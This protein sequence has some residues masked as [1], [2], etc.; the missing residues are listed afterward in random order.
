MSLKYGFYNSVNHDRVY[1]AGDFASIF[2]GII[3][4]GVFVTID[5]ALITRPGTGMQVIVGAGKAWF[6]HTWSTLDA[7]MQLAI[8]A[9]HGVYPRVDA[10]VL[11]VDAGNR[12]N[13]IK[14][15]NG[16]AASSPQ[17]PVLEDYQHPLAYVTVPKNATSISAAN[18]DI[19][20]GTS[21]CPFVTGILETVNIDELL[22]KWNQVFADDRT[23]QSAEFHA[24]FDHLVSELSENQAANL[25]RQIDETNAELAT[26][27]VFRVGDFLNTKR[28]DLGDNWALCNGETYFANEIPE[29]ADLFV[30]TKLTQESSGYKSMESASSSPFNMC[31]RMV[32]H[33]P[34]LMGH[35]NYTS[36]KRD[37]IIAVG[38][39][40]LDTAPV[41][42]ADVDLPTRSLEE[43]SIPLIAYNETTHKY[44][45]YL[46]WAGANLESPFF[47]ETSLDP[48]TASA[49]ASNWTRCTS[50]KTSVSD[51]DLS[52]FIWWNGYY[53]ASADDGVYR[54]PNL[55]QD[56]WTKVLSASRVCFSIVDDKL[57]ALKV[58][59]SGTI[60]ANYVST[61]FGTWSN[62]TFTLPDGEYASAPARLYKLGGKYFVEGINSLYMYYISALASGTLTKVPNITLSSQA[63]T[64]A[65]LCENADY[66]FAYGYGHAY[67]YGNIL[68]SKKISGQAIDFADASKWEICV[69][70]A[71]DQV[72]IALFSEPDSN[73]VTAFYRKTGSSNLKG[74]ILYASD[75]VQIPSISLSSEFYT[76]VKIADTN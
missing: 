74:A 31:A 70:L 26:L 35:R 71:E 25:Q 15:I 11:E 27:D 22:S 63:H 76:Y 21:E 48:V 30:V 72:V 62:I 10:V 43:G 60:T 66:Y 24:W 28:I 50:V 64:I 16:T 69:P 59:S 23:S 33:R 45:V 44:A 73:Y 4:D 17:R 68:R 14:V 5:K 38:D 54:C 36:D 12:T 51:F 49:A 32:N 61:P 29:A 2:D 9:A 53:F 20:V 8:S 55:S 65:H 19:M 37:H 67:G 18:I 47:F 13:S 7:D 56:Q 42:N 58:N 6:D 39:G 75:L 40:L 41:V 3:N 57:F 52:D 34:M 46:R 1:E